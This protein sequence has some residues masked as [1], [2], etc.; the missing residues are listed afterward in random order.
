MVPAVIILKLDFTD[1]WI[2]KLVNYSHHMLRLVWHRFTC[3]LHLVRIK[4]TISIIIYL[5]AIM[6]QQISQQSTGFIIII[7]IFFFFFSIILFSSFFFSLFVSFLFL[8]GFCCC[9]CCCFWFCCC[10]FFI[11]FY[12]LF[13]IFIYYFFCFVFQ[14]PT[15][16]FINIQY[17]IGVK[18]NI[19]IF[20]YFLFLLFVLKC[21]VRFLFCCFLFVS[22]V[23]C[24]CY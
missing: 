20:R 15:W 19:L 16:T 3:V 11:S 21:P 9:C 13:Y 10:F 7:T 24:F 1:R 22:L 6:Q 4:V 18:D 8:G 23:V 5:L 14:R 17:R 12:I 2:K